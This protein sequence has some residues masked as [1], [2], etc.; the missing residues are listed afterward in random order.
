MCSCLVRPWNDS[1]DCSCFLCIAK[2]AHNQNHLDA[3]IALSS[4]PNKTG[5]L[6]G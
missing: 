3:R 1:H 2:L 4:H 6:G 5:L